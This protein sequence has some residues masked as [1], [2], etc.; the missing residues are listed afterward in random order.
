MSENSAAEKQVLPLQIVTIVWMCIEVSLS[1]FGAVRAHSPALAGF[2]GDS[3]VELASASIVFL[4]FKQGS[5]INEQKAT[6]FA[7]WLL[8]A[9]AVFIATSS[10]LVLLN[11]TLH[12]EPSY[13][14]IILLAAAALVM[15]LLAKRKRKLAVETDSGSLKADAAQS[16][17]CG[18]LAWI[19]LAGLMANAFFKIHW[20]DPVAALLLLPIVL[21]EAHEAWEGKSCSHCDG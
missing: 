12:P 13:L 18:Y 4:R 21:K 11:P 17:L 1:I 19:A 5:R 8:F 6:R 2:G 3:A 20:A 16:L 14:G 7:A 15:P 10:I 9:L